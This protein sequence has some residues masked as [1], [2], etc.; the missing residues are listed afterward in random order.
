MGAL[1]LLDLVGFL[2]YE[3]RNL[4]TE[5]P[6]PERSTGKPFFGYTCGFCTAKIDCPQ[7]FGVATPAEP[8]GEKKTFF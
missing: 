6:P 3:E 8:R 4:V 1:L 2:L 7:M 5:G